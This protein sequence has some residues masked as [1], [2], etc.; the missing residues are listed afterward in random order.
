MENPRIRLA[1]FWRR[2]WALIALGAAAGAL[3]AY[4]YGSRA[5]PRYEAE[6]QVLVAGG[7]GATS[8]AAAL[9]PTYAELVSS[10]PV[11]AYARRTTR[12]PGSLDELR[13]KIRGES[14][15][16]TRLITIRADD[17]DPAR[18]IALANGLAAGLR[19]YVSVTPAPS[20]GAHTPP[21][22]KIQ[23]VV[24]ASSAARVRPVSSLLL[25][26]GALAGLLG[27]LAFVLVAEVC[28]PNV[29]DEDDLT[30]LG[31][32][33]VLGSVNGV[34][35]AGTSFPDPAQS[36]LEESAAYRR[37][38]SGIM[39]ASNED[40]PRS[41]VLVGAEGSEASWSVGVKLAFAFAED[42]RRVVLVDFEGNQ[43][44]RFFRFG[45]RGQTAALKRSEPLT[46]CDTTFDRFSVRSGTSLVLALPRGPSPTLSHE[47]ARTLL[48][49][50]SGGA[51][52]LIVHAP[53]PSRSRSALTW[54]QAARG[55]VLVVREGETPR[56]SVVTALEGLAPAGRKVLGTVLQTRRA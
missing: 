50:L 3:A 4:V 36:S 6:A 38:A 53:P 33:P 29:T 51:D 34:S 7:E 46:A 43:M 5:T 41:L 19:R 13:A 17:P 55:T 16:D 28:R 23:E 14:N 32:L 24:P 44:R 26:F 11:L 2:W 42:G 52:L 49:R 12:T 15:Q 10:T 1:S 8:Q 27:A 37:L 22:V 21:T 9:L 47:A 54:A 18:A 39:V 31:G 48:S 35:R 56:A 30:E 45:K 25:E 40:A 20:P